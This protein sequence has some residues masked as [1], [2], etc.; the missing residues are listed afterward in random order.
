[1][2]KNPKVDEAAQLA[3]RM[4]Q[5][6]ESQRSFGGDAYPPTLRY[7]GELCDGAPSHD[8]IVKAAGKKAFTAKAVVT[9]KVNKQPSLDAPVYFKEDVPKPEEVLARRMLKV[10]ESQRR[11][12]GAA[13]PPTLRRLAELC[14]VKRSDARVPKAA[15]HA[16][17]ADRTIVAATVGKK[18]N[19]DAPVV[20]KEDLEGSLSPVL[21]ALLRFVLSPVTTTRKK[22]KVET[23][24]FNQADASKR[25]I[26]DLRERFGEAL[27]R[28][29]AR[30]DLP[31]GIAW[32]TIKGAPLL[33]LA[34]N[35][36]PG[37]PLPA[38]TDDRE[39]GSA[40]PN[41]GTT[42]VTAPPPAPARDLAGAFE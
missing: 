13:Y 6:L 18:P 8:L 42:L 19:L 26:P 21:P 2:P 4:L 30:Q 3:E 10:L 32:I 15:A 17:L 14:E 7:L 27:E 33:F 23:A 11:L 29:I 28:G 16:L 37:V 36:R 39:T 31:P 40:S 38:T 12:G 41:Q 25:L 34:E 5:V 22:E 9:E 35:L 20:L 1:M 24:A